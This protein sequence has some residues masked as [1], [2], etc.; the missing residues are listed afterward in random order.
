MG[1]V[2]TPSAVVAAFVVVFPA[3]LPDKTMF[4]SI[5]LSTRYRR[6]LAVYA[7]VAAA[8]LVHMVLAAALGGLIS[9]LPSTPVDVA[10]AVLF[11]VGAVV[12]W[13]E[14]GAEE[15]P[16]RDLAPEEGFWRVAGASF[17]VVALAEFG[18]LT[19]LA[20]AS[21]AARTGDPVGTAVGATL[22]V[23]TVAAI[24]VV[25]GRALLRVLPVRAVRRVAA[26]IFLALAAWTVYE[27]VTG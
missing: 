27:I 24:A 1:P 22:A 19:Q 13:R 25:S 9:R 10:V 15:D 23:W 5:T 17:A 21:V 16:A 6:A 4:A 14:G 3:E 20:T 18:D 11:T 2:L 7:G 12:L 8:F 26:G